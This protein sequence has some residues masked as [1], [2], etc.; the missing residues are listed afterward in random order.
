[1]ATC[2]DKVNFEIVISNKKTYLELRREIQDPAASSFNNIIDG[3]MDKIEEI[4]TLSCNNDTFTE[5]RI[6]FAGADGQLTE[7]EYFSYNIT[8]SSG[9]PVL[10]VPEIEVKDIITG[11]VCESG[12][13]TPGIGSYPDGT[14]VCWEEGKCVESHINEDQFVMGVVKHGKDEPIIFGAEPILVTGKIEEGDYL[15]TSNKPGHCKGV[16]RGKIFKKDLFGKVIAQ[17]LESCDE[18]SKLIKAMI[19]KM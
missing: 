12:L 13:R 19:R 6:P 18:E 16:K 3:L 7:N 14:V 2:D 8:G 5:S 1:M 4:R 15:V 10:Q 9:N 11:A 17:A